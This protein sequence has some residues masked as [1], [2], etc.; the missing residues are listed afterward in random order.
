MLLLPFWG[1]EGFEASGFSSVLGF[2][3]LGLGFRLCFRSLW[4][5]KEVQCVG[6][7]CGFR[8]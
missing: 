8:V 6:F 3:V 7:W 5:K 4:L 2:L 1:V